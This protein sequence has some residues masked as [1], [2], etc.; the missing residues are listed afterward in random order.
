MLSWLL[1]LLV[2]PCIFI[3]GFIVIWFIQGILEL[4]FWLGKE[5]ELTPKAIFTGIVLLFALGFCVYIVHGV[6]A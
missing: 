1:S 5:G 6:I 3:A 2:I 4:S